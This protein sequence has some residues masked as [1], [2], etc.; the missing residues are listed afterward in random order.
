MA[1]RFNVIDKRRH[2]W[3]TKAVTPSEY[4][5]LEQI[6]I[7]TMGANNSRSTIMSKTEF[8]L[9]DLSLQLGYK[10]PMKIWKLLKDLHKKNLITREHTR[11]KGVEVIGLNPEVFGQVLIN[12]HHEL[13]KTRHL[14]LVDNSKP[15]Q[16]NHLP[17]TNE[18]FVDHKR[19]V[20]EPQTK[21]LQNDDQISD[22]IDENVLLE[23][24]RS[25]LES[26]K[27][28]KPGELN[29]LTGGPGAG[30]GA[31]ARRGKSGDWTKPKTQEEL[32]QE[33]ERQL[34]AY[35]SEIE[36]EKKAGTL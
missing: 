29:T 5:L 7:G 18:S 22:I 11:F 36:A 31:S 13:E 16:T 19:S 4:F 30:W 9:E 1:L 3:I 20:C 15:E 35:Q 27:G 10:S 8:I 34:K 23:S 33:M 12:K 21:C 26:L 6:E 25:I 14:K 2:L 28:Q 17:I 32:Q 24:S